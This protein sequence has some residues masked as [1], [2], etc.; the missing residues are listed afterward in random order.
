[1][2]KIGPETPVYVIS[3]AARL[4][5]VHAQTLRLY[6]REG[7]IEPHRS[8]KRRIYSESDI[9]RL[10][11]ICYLTR[12]RRV[13]LSGVKIIL[14]IYDNGERNAI[15]FPLVKVEIEEEMGD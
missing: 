12:V 5:G 8:G 6:E 4:V 13:N 10:R 2:E 15:N 9:G 14:E 1:M 7:L 3:V 11:Y